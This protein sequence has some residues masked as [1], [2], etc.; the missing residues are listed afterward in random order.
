MQISENGL[1]CLE[2]WEGLELHIYRDSASNQSIGIGHKLTHTEIVNGTFVN[3]ITEERAKEI[4]RDDIGPCENII[5]D[6]V[7][8]DLSQNQFDALCIFTF[9]IG[10][11]GFASST[12]LRVLN[13]GYYDMVP[14]AMRL[15]NKITVDGKHVVDQGL[16]NR[17]EKE[18]S[19]FT[20]AV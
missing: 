7:K 2:D 9:N 15:W 17:R 3:G 20:E 11:G 5:N 19:L 8:V 13:Q 12:V 14:D 4:C 18:I 10:L 6:M 1:K 16:V